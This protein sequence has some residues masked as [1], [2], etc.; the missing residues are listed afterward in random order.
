MD[1]INEVMPVLWHVL[2]KH[3]KGAINVSTVDENLTVNILLGRKRKSF[4][5]NNPNLLLGDITQ[6]ASTM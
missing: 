6:F 5:N 3:K 2:S 1:F 4:T